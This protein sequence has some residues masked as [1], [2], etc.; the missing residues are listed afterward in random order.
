LKKRILPILLVIIFAASLCA[1]LYGCNPNEDGGK[2]KI[3]ATIFPCYDFAR[4]VSGGKADITMLVKAGAEVHS[5]D[6]APLDIARIADCDIFIYIGGQSDVWVDKILASVNTENITVVRLMDFVDAK[7]E[8]HSEGM[9]EEEREKE[10]A[11]DE[12]I[13]T[14]P[15]NAL[16]L[17]DAVA[18]AVSEVDPENAELYAANAADYKALITELQE[19]F[20]ELAQSAAQKT[21]IVADRFPFLYFADEFGLDYFAA[22][23]ACSAHNDISGQTLAFLINK[24]QELDV[25]CVYYIELSNQNVARTLAEETGCQT[26]LLHSCQSVAADE[27]N[28]G[29]TYVSLMRANLASLAIAL[30]NG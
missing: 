27:F 15:A 30:G 28:A 25:K 22:F 13:W 6:P 12:H 3:V 17:V 8:E 23:P 5:F 4:A 16:L 10:H 7:E 24:I 20:A 19:D 2:I 29:A 21:F 9:E 26:A 18:S 14:S 11:Y 1:G